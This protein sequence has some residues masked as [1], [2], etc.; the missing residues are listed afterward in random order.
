MRTCSEYSFTYSPRERLEQNVSYVDILSLG[1]A[2]WTD[3]CL[4]ELSATSLAMFVSLNACERRV[5][6]ETVHERNMKHVRALHLN[7]GR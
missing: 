3:S 6:R 1:S 2:S 4:R 7:G 5:R